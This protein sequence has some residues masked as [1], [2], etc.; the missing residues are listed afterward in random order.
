MSTVDRAS[1]AA[2]TISSDKVANEAVH[3]RRL[4]TAVVLAGVLA[5]ASIA[6][7]PAA[8]H[9]PD[10]GGHCQG[11]IVNG[12]LNNTGAVINNC[13]H[14]GALNNTGLAAV[15][16][17]SALGAWI[18]NLLS[19]TG[20]ATV[21]NFGRWTGDA[22]N[23][24]T[25]VNSGIWN[26][27]AAGFT[28]SG[29]LI[30]T[31]TLNVAAG[32]LTNTGAVNA[33][34]L[35]KGDIANM[36]RG[37]FTVT[38]PLA[39]GGG[40]FLNANGAI[41]NV[42]ASVFND[43]G[44]LTNSAAGL[45]NIAGGRLG[46]ITTVNAGT[47]NVSGLSTMNGSLTNS[48]IINL[49]NNVVGDRL[50]ISGNFTGTAGSTIALDLNARAGI[51]DQVVITGSASGSTTLNVAGLAP[52]SPFTI[53]P[54]LV[55]VQA[56]AALN[57]FNLVN[58]QIFGTLQV[59]LLPQ[60]NGAGVSF[61]PVTVAST[62]GLSGSVATTAAQTASFV[63]NEAAFDR[64]AGLRNSIRADSPQ[65]AAVAATAYA[66]EFAKNDPISPYVRA[67]AATAAPGGFG[68]P[69]SAVWVKGYGDYEQ[70]DEQASFSIAGASFSSNLGYRQ[71]TGGV[72]GGFDAVWSGLASSTDG[73]VLGVLGGYIYSRVDLRDSPTSQI[74][75][76]P[77]V[78]VYGT[79]LT[80]NWF[81][82]SLFK[83]DLL[84]LDIDIPGISQSANPTNYNLATNIGYKFELPN[85]YYIEPTA[86]LEYVRTN[87]DHASALTATTAPLNNGDALRTRAG[88]RI[89]AEWVA[90]SVRVEPSLLAL[91]W[92]IADATNN[93][94]LVNDTSISLP[95][96]VGRL[97]G[98]LQ[99]LVNVFDLQTGLSGF[100]RVDSRFGDGLW[101][102]GGKA[103][104]RYQW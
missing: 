41:L 66:Q 93:A 27:V 103:G 6:A 92:E 13:L 14:I 56:G 28:N 18:G 45:I 12:L 97:R 33:Q 59:V 24:S 25:V 26:T 43:I 64:M 36:D 19:N 40:N 85:H 11:G 5:L 10:G 81:L 84:S 65:N 67:E 76:G 62:A 35:I 49:Q 75:S 1:N 98:E 68:N 82:D 30:T 53:G 74:F 29:T 77:S 94:L 63:S 48:G 7:G 96:D 104:V 89:G 2:R 9:D 100:A 34:G 44:T 58:L 4:T 95:S 22:N 71:G 78:G 72:M 50:T 60:A 61:A 86:G 99:G 54:N 42:G 8:A 69:K 55:V 46:A 73:L 38:G 3:W 23:A 52:G 101:S 17:N 88:A 102:V 21:N 79:Y 37:I 16:T 32:G 87:F 15:V 83:A 91:V 31:G 70:R 39:A 80:G 20:G 57:A 47:I 90:G 51:A